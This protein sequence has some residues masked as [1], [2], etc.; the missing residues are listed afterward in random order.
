MKKILLLF[1]LISGFAYSQNTFVHKGFDLSKVIIENVEFYDGFLDDKVVHIYFDKVIKSASENNSYKVY[2]HT[3]IEE[4]KKEFV[5][6]ITFRD[7]F[8]VKNRSE[9]VL[10]FGDFSFLNVENKSFGI[11]GKVRMEV[12]K[13][14]K[15]ETG[16]TIT[17]KG[18]YTDTNGSEKIWFA[19]FYPN[20]I[21]AVIFR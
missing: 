4:K 14:P 19:N 20:N 21:D 15:E 16:C 6:E 13:F 17:F 1:I 12:D 11:K 9:S 3:E 5:G 7:S 8:N 18:F 10:H 2:A